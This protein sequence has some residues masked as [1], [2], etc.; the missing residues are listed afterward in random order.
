MLSVYLGGATLPAG[1]ECSSSIVR[2]KLMSADFQLHSVGT[3][4]LASS[5][6]KTADLNSRETMEMVISNRMNWRKT[7]SDWNTQIISLVEN[8][9]PQTIQTAET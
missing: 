5:Q 6:E 7:C 1:I 2:G 8:K 4:Y 9:K 3:H